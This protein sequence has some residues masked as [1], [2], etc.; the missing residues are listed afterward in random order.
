MSWATGQVV[1]FTVPFDETA[2]VAE[3]IAGIKE[4]AAEA[5]GRDPA[6]MTG[7]A[8]S[9]DGCAT[10]VRLDDNTPEIKLPRGWVSNATGEFCPGC[11][12][13]AN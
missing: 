12:N 7:L 4:K 5:L 11:K 6:D 3:R 2:T 9:C 10:V 8:V 13:R 1:Q